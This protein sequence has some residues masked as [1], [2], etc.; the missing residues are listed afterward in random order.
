MEKSLAWGA[1]IA[2]IES[3]KE[4]HQKNML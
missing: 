3:F 1:A 4:T 2:F